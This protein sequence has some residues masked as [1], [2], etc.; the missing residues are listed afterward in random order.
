[1]PFIR[2]CTAAILAV[3]SAVSLD[4]RQATAPAT[5]P[6]EGTAEFV[7]FAAGR[8]IGRE[9]V[10]V[11]KS[12]GSWI[13][14]STGRHAAPIDITINRFEMKYA[15]DW[16]PIELSIDASAGS[17]SARAQDV[18]RSDHRDQRD[19]PGHRHQFED[20]PGQ[21]P[22]GR[23]SQ[24]V[25]RCLR[26]AC[27]PARRCD[28]RDRDPAL[29]RAPGRDQSDRQRSCS[30][31]AAGRRQRHR[32]HG[33][34]A[35]DAEPRRRVDGEGGGRF[36]RTARP[37]RDGWSRTDHRPLGPGISRRSSAAHPQRDRR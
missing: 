33:L 29:R 14:T 24:R 10:T 25:L 13:I 21:C 18:V 20:R 16:Q 36:R 6:R 4:A 1:M 23:P 15:A 12:G 5:G 32:D 35:V 34:R 30:A 22:N 7:V 31:A 3:L 17:Q 37:R 9:Q 28:R 8:Q 2:N 19:Y 27:R 26:S 11:A